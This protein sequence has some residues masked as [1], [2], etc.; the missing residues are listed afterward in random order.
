M[1]EEELKP[2]ICSK[3]RGVLINGVV[4]HH[5]NTWPHVAVAIVE[6]N[7][8]LKFITSPSPSIQSRSS[9]IWL[10]HF[11]TV[12]GCITWWRGQGHGAYMASHASENILHRWHQRFMEQHN[13]CVEKLGNYVK[14]DSIF[15]LVYLL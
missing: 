10:P 3:R 9:P 8:K 4:L 13:K 1:L 2:T 5:D 14:N 6:K 12:Q 15:V 11:W 7:Q